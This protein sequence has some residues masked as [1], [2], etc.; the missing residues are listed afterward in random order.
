M[1]CYG[2]CAADGRE[3]S[4]ASSTMCCLLLHAGNNNR[5]TAHTDMNR[6]SSRSHAIL[7][8]W[9]EQRPSADT[10]AENSRPGT[11]ADVVVRS[12]MNFVDLAGSERWGKAHTE[13][14]TRTLINELTS[15]NNSLSA[16]ALVVAALTD[17][18]AKHVPYRY[19]VVQDMQGCMCR[20]YQVC[21]HMSVSFGTRRK[22]KQPA[23]RYRLMMQETACSALH[24]DSNPVTAVLPCG[25]M[26]HYVT[27]V[28]AGPVG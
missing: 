5:A 4:F 3:S 8:L 9:L 21:Q 1:K 27:M 16:L 12:K 24:S 20:G 6:H 11:A 25:G 28:S 18:T 15:I 7:Q 14:E 26:P 17:K 22:A 2:V 19:G 23:C 10:A 13:S